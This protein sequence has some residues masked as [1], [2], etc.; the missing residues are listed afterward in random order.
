MPQSTPKRILIYSHDTYG[1]GHLRRSLLIAGGLASS[2]YEPQ[3]LIVT[4]SPRTNAFALP[5]GCDTVKLPAVLKQGDGTYEPRTLRGTFD[6]IR[7]LRADIILATASSFR[8]DAIIVDHAPL[9]MKGELEPLFDWVGHLSPEDRPKMVL[10][11]RDVIDDP[12]RVEQEWRKLGVWDRLATIYDRIFVYGDERIVSTAEELGLGSRVPGKVQH[13]GYISRPHVRL[14]RA[15]RAEDRPTILVTAGGGGDGQGL[16]RLYIRF[17]ESLREPARFRS[18]IVTGPFLSARRQ[19][20]VAAHLRETGH[21]FELT[22]FV[23]DLESQIASAAGVIAMAGYN[24][25]TEILAA[26]VPALLIPREKPRQEQL[27]RARSLGAIGAVEY[28]RAKN[29]DPA[30]IGSFVERALRV[31]ARAAESIVCLDGLQNVAHAMSGILGISADSAD[32]G[33]PESR[34]HAAG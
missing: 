10:G 3:V 33:R 25:V 18:R 15:A 9:G 11:L 23:V 27:I 5:P 19:R 24:T 14:H 7:R 4:G 30:T 22:E 20:E 1:L 34:A 28:C 32:D 29:C 21:P 16:L 26:C 31:K 12:A 8:P 2:S 13:V 6:A 17:L